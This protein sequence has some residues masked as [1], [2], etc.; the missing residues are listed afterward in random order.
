MRERLP[1]AGLAGSCSARRR[2]RGHRSRRRHRD[3]GRRPGRGRPLPPRPGTPGADR[4][5]GARHRPLR[6]RGDGRRGGRGLRR[7]RRPA[8]PD[9]AECLELLDG[10]AGARDG[11]RD[12]YR[13]R[14]P[15]P[16][17]GADSRGDRGRPRARRRGLRRPR[18]RQPGDLLVLTGELGGAAAGLLL[19]ERPELA[20]A[21]PPR[22]PTTCAGASS[23]PSPASAPDGR[24]RGP[25]RR[26]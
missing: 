7:A 26:R 4:P 8:G 12:G 15:D 22:P 25:E 14:R 23:T 16:G 6:P 17:A 10:L 19:L 20:D 1:A 18:R 9:E 5:Q 13:R 2:R 3:L 24:W 21:V 11:D